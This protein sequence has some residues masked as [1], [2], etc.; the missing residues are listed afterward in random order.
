MR[1]GLMRW[2]QDELPKPVLLD[3]RARLKAAIERDG[4]DAFLIYT[5][6]VRPSA[7]C[8]L[9]G[10]TPYWIDSLLLIAQDGSAILATALS[11]RVAD[12]VRSTSCLDE[13]INTPRPGAAIGERLAGDNCKR[14]GV[15]ELDGLPAGHYDDLI[16]A[17]AGVE[18]VDATEIFAGVR[19]FIDDTERRLIERADQIAVAALAQVDANEATEASVLAGRIEKHARLNAAEEVYVAVAPD[20]DADR[21]LI[22][23]LCSAALGR[24]F[25]VRASV[26]YKG[27][28]VR[29]TR[30]FARDTAG[31]AVIARGDAWLAQLVS[32]I[33]ADKPL[34]TVL[35]AALARRPGADLVNWMAETSV[36]SYPLEV[37]ASSRSGAGNALRAGSFAVLTV[38][39]TIDSV[40]WLGAAPAFVA[41][42]PKTSSGI[43]AFA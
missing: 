34:N 6:L 11:K 26:A 39:L 24:R 1:R 5:N 14:V 10:F 18:L 15:L 4:L 33:P 30:A 28:W 42:P 21:R 40:P 7:V 22:S 35:A 31:A 9:T 20:L 17:A 43:H 13:I 8:W 36:R 38:E 23:S 27:S 12:W 16:A 37:V 3:R 2:D 32:S 41:K 25:A 19:R 29:R